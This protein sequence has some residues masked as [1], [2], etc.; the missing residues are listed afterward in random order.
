M[1]QQFNKTRIAPTPSG[2]LH[3]GNVLSFAVTAAL[4]RKTGAKVLLRIDDMDQARVNEAYVQ[5]VFETLR[6]LEIPFDEGPRSAGEFETAYSQL[7]RLP[8]YKSALNKLT[9]G[10]LVFACTCTRSQLQNGEKCNCAD[11]N[12]P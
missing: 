9:D 3:L 4:A 8:F 10:G 5:D 7:H 11:K 6:F 2:Y 12:I 1:L